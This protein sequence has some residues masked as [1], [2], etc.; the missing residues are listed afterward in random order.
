MKKIL[1]FS[2]LICSIQFALAQPAGILDETFNLKSIRVND[3]YLTPNDENPNFTIHE[4]A[5]SYTVEA[6]GIENIFSS[7]ATFDGNTITF[8]NPGTTSEDCNGSNCY[9]E[10]LY[11]Y[12]VL[13]NQNLESKTLTFNYHESNGIKTLSLRDADYNVASFSTESQP[14]P[15]PLLFQTWYLYM[16]VGDL[17]DPVFY[18]GP[19]PPQIKINQDF[20]Y[21]GLEGCATISGDF[22]L[23]A[24]EN[25]DFLLQ[26][27]N[28]MTDE[29]NC[30][31]GNVVYSMYDLPYNYPLGCILYEGND[32]I[33]Y[34]QYETYPGFISYF[35]NALILSTPE[36]SLAALKI[37]PNPVENKLIIQSP[38]NN[39]DS[40]SITDINGRIV[41]SLKNS[42]SNEIEV[43]SLKSG[44]YFITITSS[45]GNITKKFIKN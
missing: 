28:Y 14:E 36:N 18:N 5:G 45:Q 32:G 27:Q 11:F 33:D 19:N 24:A 44:I 16:T 42:I 17:G 4:N 31:P 10:D 41:K 8:Q 3:T 15:N 38:I 1:L 34:F 13:T 12:D 6:N 22:I 26:S 23:G 21:T 43:S 30:P 37:F 7:G 9:F 35:R 2:T 40:V 20:T 39:F 25:Y 29:S